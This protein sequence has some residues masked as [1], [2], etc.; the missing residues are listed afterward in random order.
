MRTRTVAD[1]SISRLKNGSA[2]LAISDPLQEQRLYDL[3]SES[4]PAL[5]RFTME[6][7]FGDIYAQSTLISKSRHLATLVAFVNLGNAV[8]QL[9][10]HINIGL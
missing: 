2:Q 5:I 9:R 3:L 10:F 8:D 1:T 4:S 6:Y 7:D